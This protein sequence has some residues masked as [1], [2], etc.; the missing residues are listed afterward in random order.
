VGTAAEGGESELNACIDAAH[1]AFFKWRTT[2]R[3]ERS[4]LLR[5]IAATV[6]DREAEL[7]QLL[8]QE[9]GKPKTWSK[10]EVARLALTFDYAADALS[11]FGLE[12]I[13][14]D[15]DPRGGDYVCSSERVP[16]GPIFCMVPYNWPFNLTAHKVAPALA[17]GN[18]VIVKTS[19]LAPMSTLALVRLIHEC[20]APNGVI[21]AWNGADRYVLPALADTRVKMLS[22]TGSARVGWMLKKE[23]FDRPVALE[24]GG[25]GFVVLD[26]SASLDWA[27]KRIVAGGFGYAGQVCIAVQHV[28]AHESIYEEL[29]EGLT[30][31]VKNC[32]TGD[33][34]LEST[35][36]GPLISTS[37]ADKVEATV[38][39]AALAGGSIL[40]HGARAGNVVAPVLLENVPFETSMGCEE[41]FGPVVDIAP[42]STLDKAIERVNRSKYGIQL[43]L[44]TDCRRSVERFYREVET[45]GLIVNDYPTLRFDNVPYGGVKQSGFGREGVRYA[46]EEMTQP[47]ALVYKR[48]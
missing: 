27:V 14:V 38:E 43:G 8:V 30:A 44:F 39:Q 3:G 2:P 36:C 12:S 45:G 35:V 22:F 34:Q 7:V 10:G 4:R 25:D 19:P 32:R 24:L 28:L 13:P 16:R 23:V 41:V 21:N 18:T 5:K 48:S 29:R 37:A 15:L 40:V 11:N 17:S 20:G 33:P 26:K 31:A 46:M 9:V 6:R 1:D 42:F 47:K